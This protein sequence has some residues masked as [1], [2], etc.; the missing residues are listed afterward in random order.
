MALSLRSITIANFRTVLELFDPVWDVLYPTERSRILRLL[1]EKVDLDSD[2]GRIGI[3]FHP[4]GIAALH[5]E[6]M[7]VRQLATQQTEEA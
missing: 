7:N 6:M 3:R 5:D 2:T 1:I 4:T